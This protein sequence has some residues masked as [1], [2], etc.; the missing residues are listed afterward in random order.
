ML[1]DDDFGGTALPVRIIQH[2]DLIIAD[3]TGSSPNV[4]YE[5]GVA[6]ALRKPALVIAQ[7]PLTLTGDFAG[8]KLVTY[9][10]EEYEK[11]SR[12]IQYWAHENLESS[13]PGMAVAL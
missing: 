8:H 9:G 4:F 6:D 5:L 7:K 13:L 3:I 2:A 12:F 10:P 1:G 11:L